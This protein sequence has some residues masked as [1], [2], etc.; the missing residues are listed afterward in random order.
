MLE[1]QRLSFGGRPGWG[2]GNRDRAGGGLDEGGDWNR[3][4][5]GLE[6]QG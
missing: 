3:V 1:Q 6:C 4:G 2:L 5:V